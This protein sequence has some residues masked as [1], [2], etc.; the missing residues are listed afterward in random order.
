MEGAEASAPAVSDSE[1]LAT[2]STNPAYKTINVAAE[3][4][5]MGSW[6]AV[7]NRQPTRRRFVNWLNRCD[8]P[9]QAQ[10]VQ[11]EFGSVRSK[12]W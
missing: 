1:W 12:D 10:N 11:A 4:A 8:K 6:C 7:N 9:M 5:K 2:L 3:F